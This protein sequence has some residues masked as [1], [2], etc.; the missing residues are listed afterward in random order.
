MIR[1]RCP[2]VDLQ[3]I[4]H[5]E[6]H[7]ISQQEISFLNLSKMVSRC[8]KL[9]SSMAVGLLPF[10]AATDDFSIA[11]NTTI[12]KRGITLTPVMNGMNFPDP[13]VI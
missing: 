11:D 9:I 3:Y 4:L 8:L 6:Y 7:I 13:S 10:A 12:E 2:L 1:S 5:E